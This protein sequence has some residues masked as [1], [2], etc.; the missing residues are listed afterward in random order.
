[1]RFVLYNI[2]YGTGGGRIRFPFNGYLRRTEKNFE[3]IAQFLQELRPDVAGLVEVDSGSYRSGRNNQAQLISERLGHCHV[4]RSKYGEHSLTR[5]IP[6]LNRQGNAFVVRNSGHKE[7]FHYFDRGVKRLVIELEMEEVTFFLIHLA[8][9]SRLR[10][11]QLG[12]LYDLLQT[13]KKPHIV[14]GDFNAL[15][16]EQEIRLFQAATRLRNAHVANSPTFPSWKPQRHLDFILHS[17]GIEVER[18]WMPEI[19]LSDH[20]PIVC[21]FHTV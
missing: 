15:W 19:H 20:L 6:V 17:E 4:Y 8:L 12:D 16:G 10:H 3:R 2:R 7:T 13:V 11:R 5:H 1:M 9:G 18:C 14:A 21:D